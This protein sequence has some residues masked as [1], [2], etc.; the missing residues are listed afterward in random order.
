MKIV[1]IVEEVFLKFASIIPNVIGAIIV[2][3]IGLLVARLIAKGIRILLERLKI[4]RLADR[5]NEIDLVRKSG[6]TLRLSY[7]ISQLLYYILLLVFLVVA[8]DILGMAVVSMMVSD[9]IA[10]VPRLLSALVLF[11]LGLL[12]SEGIRKI[13]L[14]TCA[15]LNIPSGRVIATFV[16][17]IVFLTMTISALAQAGIATELITSNLSILLGAIA[18]AFSLGYGLASRDTMANFLASFYTKNKVRAGDELLV[19]GKR[20]TVVS[21]DATSVTLRAENRI[22]VVPLKKITSDTIEII[23]RS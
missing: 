14:G 8:T 9:L 5:L 23:R 15:A 4:D 20:G 11:V 6:I 21:L 10:Y 2:I 7:F 3:I 18:F 12:L 1:R 17:Y 19:D 22:I 16:F 13:V